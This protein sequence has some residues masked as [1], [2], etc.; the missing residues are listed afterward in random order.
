M[1]AIDELINKFGNMKT[2]H[3]NI[4]KVWIK[5]L[6]IKK[7]DIQNIINQGESTLL[8]CD[9]SN[10]IPIISMALLNQMASLGLTNNIT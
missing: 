10:D 8:N 3:P 9:T 2:T 1:D 7:K 5:F 4:S 6:S